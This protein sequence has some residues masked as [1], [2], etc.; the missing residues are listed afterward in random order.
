MSLLSIMMDAWLPGKG[1]A[2]ALGNNPRSPHGDCE[3]LGLFPLANMNPGQVMLVTLLL[4][5]QWALQLGPS[6]NNKVN[7]QESL[8]ARLV[9]N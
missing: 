5:F 3:R 6:H 8:V 9:L 2:Q 4:L 1:R 7:T